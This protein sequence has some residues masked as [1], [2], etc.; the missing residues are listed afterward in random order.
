M[1]R[2]TDIS[3]SKFYET[4]TGMIVKPFRLI[5]PEQ[6]AVLVWEPDIGNWHPEADIVDIRLIECETNDPT[7]A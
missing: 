3:I 2:D 5:Y 6:W 1:M 4:K 7:P